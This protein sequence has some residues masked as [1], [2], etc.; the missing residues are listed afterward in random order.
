V[1]PSRVA[2]PTAAQSDAAR[3]AAAHAEV[4]EALGGGV[5][6]AELDA[7]RRKQ[8]REMRDAQA[9]ELLEA[10]KRRMGR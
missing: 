4:D 6:E 3:E 2:G 1:D 10:L 8:A 9:E 7:L 5:N